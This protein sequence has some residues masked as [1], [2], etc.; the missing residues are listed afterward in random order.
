MNSEY[1]GIYLSSEKC[2]RQLVDSS[3]Q[4]AQANLS[5]AELGRIAVP[6]PPI[7]EQ[8]QIVGAIRA[9][10]S[11]IEEVKERARREVALLGEYRTTMITDVVTGKTDVREATTHLP[12]E[13]G[14]S[15]L[16]S[17]E[18]LFDESSDGVTE[19]ETETEKLTEEALG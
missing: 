11:R 14:E 5:L 1:L 15:E 17:L 3:V 8:I 7:E 4:S 18:E 16:E 13:A 12:D 2:Q 19:T 9:A 10:A 6:V